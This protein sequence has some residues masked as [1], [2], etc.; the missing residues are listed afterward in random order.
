[1]D[2]LQI[3]RPECAMAATYL[4]LRSLR[5][6]LLL[7]GADVVLG[8]AVVVGEVKRRVAL[9]HKPSHRLRRNKINYNPQK[10]KQT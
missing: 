9:V 8:R 7:K 6:L 4:A 3:V 5:P 1:M 2:G 10:N